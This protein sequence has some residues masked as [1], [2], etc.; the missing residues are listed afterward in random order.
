MYIFV[1]IELMSA[2]KKTFTPEP[3]TLLVLYCTCLIAGGV[4]VLYSMT[5]FVYIDHI[6]IHYV[7]ARNFDMSHLATF[8]RLLIL[9][10][11][12]DLGSDVFYKLK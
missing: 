12:V 3:F 6:Y 9:W 11:T 5:C 1:C 10:D 4:C 8:Y 2:T 7:S